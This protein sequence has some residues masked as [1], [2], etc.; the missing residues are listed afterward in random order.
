MAIVFACEHFEAYTYMYME[1]TMCMWNLIILY[2]SLS[3]VLR[4]DYSACYS[5]YKNSNLK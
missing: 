4:A 2:K 1:E 5:D 3:T